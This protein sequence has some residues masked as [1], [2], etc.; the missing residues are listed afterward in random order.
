L[1]K[2]LANEHYLDGI[3][4]SGG[5]PFDQAKPFAYFAAQAKKKLQLNI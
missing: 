3:T 1:L 5:D 2:D 4:F